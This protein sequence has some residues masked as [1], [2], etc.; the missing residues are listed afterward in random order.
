MLCR[1][2]VFLCIVLEEFCCFAFIRIC[3]IVNIKEPVIC[4]V[5]VC[6][7]NVF[8]MSMKH[9]VKCFLRK[10]PQLKMIFGLVMIRHLFDITQHNTVFEAVVVFLYSNGVIAVV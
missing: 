1:N 10:R 5:L 2:V 3:E 9:L 8:L 7:Q 6:M 4:T